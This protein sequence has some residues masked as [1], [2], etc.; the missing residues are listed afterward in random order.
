M[1]VTKD[2]IESFLGV[3]KVAGVRDEEQFAA[4]A[5][6][7]AINTDP[8]LRKHKPRELATQVLGN[9]DIRVTPLGRNWI[10]YGLTWKTFQESDMNAAGV[11]V[12]R[13]DD[14]FLIGNV[15]MQGGVCDDCTDLFDSDVIDAYRILVKESEF[16]G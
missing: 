12:K 1:I 14:R 13:G 6:N 8:N 7:I 2:V 15:N 4:M 11:Q 9:G 3:Q 16:N 5:K 10:G